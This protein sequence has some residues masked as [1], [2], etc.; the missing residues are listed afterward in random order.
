MEIRVDETLNIALANAEIDVAAGIFAKITNA[1][2]NIGFNRDIF[3]EDEL[4]LLENLN[5]VLNPNQEP[6]TG[7]MQ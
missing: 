3:T 6:P 7:E 5:S 1:T 4:I 2:V